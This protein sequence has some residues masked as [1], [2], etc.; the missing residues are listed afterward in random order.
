MTRRPLNTAL[1]IRRP[2]GVRAW[3]EV[4]FS[5]S[6]LTPPQPLPAEREKRAAPGGGEGG[7]RWSSLLH[8]WGHVV[9]VR[10]RRETQHTA[11]RRD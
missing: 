1:K 8:T 11:V 6:I 10:P 7:T 3:E 2:F 5:T 4:L 9:F